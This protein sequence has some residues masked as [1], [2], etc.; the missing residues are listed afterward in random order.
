MDK[1]SAKP[2]KSIFLV[3]MMGAGK[4]TFGK[5]L[6]KELGYSFYD[7][8]EELEKRTG[9]S[10][11]E[12]FAREGEEGFRRRETALLKEF[13][14]K[15]GVI[16]ATGG[17][18]VTREENRKILK[19]GCAHVVHLTVSP[20]ICFFRTKSSARPLLKTPNP[21]QTIETLMEQREPLYAE[22]RDFVLDTEKLSFKQMCKELMTELEK[23][24][25]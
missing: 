3:G 20:R 4:S 2:Y 12:I 22:V 5:Y 14:E 6:S 21:M 7:L 13:I 9:V 18:V 16:V 10:I 11:P 23:E 19:T 24:D 17:G 8:D 1:N 25:L 15:E